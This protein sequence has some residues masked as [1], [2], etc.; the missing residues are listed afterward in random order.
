MVFK[1]NSTDVRKFT[2][3][4]K[5][6]WNQSHIIDVLIHRLC[7]DRKPNEHYFFSQTEAIIIS[8]KTHVLYIVFNGWLFWNISQLDLIS[9]VS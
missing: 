3:N 8:S 6:S 7:R 2:V 4:T 9:E 5:T 1:N